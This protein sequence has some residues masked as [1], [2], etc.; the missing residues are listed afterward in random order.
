MADLSSKV[1]SAAATLWGKPAKAVKI[2]VWGDNLGAEVWAWV[3]EED[4]DLGMLS[5]R[6][7]VRPTAEKEAIDA[8][9]R[10]ELLLALLDVLEGALRRRAT[11]KS[12]ALMMGN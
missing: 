6:V 4:P 1:I 11:A 2:D 9:Y 10:A 7:W 5:Y 3:N 8:A 12:M